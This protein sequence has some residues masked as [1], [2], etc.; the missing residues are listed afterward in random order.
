MTTISFIDSKKENEDCS[1]DKILQGDCHGRMANEQIRTIYT[2]LKDKISSDVNEIIETENVKFQLSTLEEQKNSN[3]PNISSIDLGECESLLKA[4][5]NLTESD[6]LIVL[7]TD[8]KSQDL[9]STY[10]HMKYIILLL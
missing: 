2:I 8:I 3:N 5:E 4:Q 7:K 9:S 10:V 1:V 6:N